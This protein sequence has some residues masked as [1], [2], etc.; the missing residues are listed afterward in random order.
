MQLRSSFAIAEEEQQIDAFAIYRAT[1]PNVLYRSNLASSN[2]VACLG[3]A[4]PTGKF[5]DDLS[6]SGPAVRQDSEGWELGRP[7]TV[8][9]KAA[10]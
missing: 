1:R 5:L 6:N 4:K 3:K 10:S 2:P 9:L 7:K 8:T